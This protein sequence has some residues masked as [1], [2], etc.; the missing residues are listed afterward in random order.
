MRYA[1]EDRVGLILAISN[2]FHIIGVA[3]SMRTHRP[4]ADYAMP[5]IDL[6]HPVPIVSVDVE[7][8]P[9]SPMMLALPYILSKAADVSQSACCTSRTK[10]KVAPQ[11]STDAARTPGALSWR[12]SA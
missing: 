2:L 4:D 9:L 5:T 6:H 8:H 3:L 1:V 12:R 7:N 11:Q 10:R